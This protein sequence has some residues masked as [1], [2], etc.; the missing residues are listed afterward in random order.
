[1]D[2][3]IV[4]DDVSLSVWEPIGSKQ[5]KMEQI[6]ALKTSQERPSYRTF[7]SLYA[8]L[9]RDIYAGEVRLSQLSDSS[10]RE[11]FAATDISTVLTTHKDVLSAE[12]ESF[13]RSFEGILNETVAND[14]DDDLK[15][16][17]NPFLS[18]DCSCKS[19]LLASPY[20]H[21][22]E[23]S[24]VNREIRSHNFLCCERTNCST[25]TSFQKRCL[26]SSLSCKTITVITSMD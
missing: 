14:D 23:S 25:R 11:N 1:M 17:S 10:Q 12:F 21:H 18:T 6:L 16:S 4:V 9:M 24:S 8:I 15:C 26:E 20:L 3:L 13:S 2:L 22:P 19:G 7:A 5:M